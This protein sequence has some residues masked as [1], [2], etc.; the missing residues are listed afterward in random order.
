MNFDLNIN[1][2]KREELIDMLDLPANFDNKIIE[3]KEAKLID[4]IINNT[5]ISKETQMKTIQFLNE[6]KKLILHGDN[7][8]N[9]LTNLVERI[10][11]TDFTLKNTEIE[12]PGEHMVQLRQETPYISSY[13]SDYFPGTIN[14]LK[15][16]TIKRNLNIDSRF[17][18]NY[19]S[20]PSTNF[21]LVLPSI[22]TKVVS[23]QLSA[24][25]LPS[26][27]YIISKQYGNNFFTVIVNGQ[28]AVVTIPDGNYTQEFTIYQ[29]AQQQLN[30]FVTLDPDFAHVVITCNLINGESG[31]GQTIIGFNGSQKPNSTIEVNFQADKFGIEDLSTPLPLKLG[32]LMGFRNGVYVNNGSYVSESVL[33][34]TGPRYFFLVVDD[35]N[36]SV[37][38]S[39]YS[40]F[41][42]SILNKNILARISLQALPFNI[43]EQ[44]NLNIVTIT[45]DYFG[46]VNLQNLNIQ[47][48]DEYGRIVDLN[49]MDFSFCLNLTSIYDL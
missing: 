41:N 12:N 15:R 27:F 30:N 6:A 35:Y 28:S 2:Y 3:L 32:W 49:Y 31:S 36:N 46:P 24:I 16:K 34:V 18:N 8:T 14:P 4:S 26:T 45:R 37:A 13:P 7:K 43:L 42:S 1:N 47:L 5:E 10:Y 48:L 33:D 19:Y 38:N 22:F 39:F 25:E 21:N 20:S 40:A 9:N 23:M 11:Q 44:S 17:R 29:I